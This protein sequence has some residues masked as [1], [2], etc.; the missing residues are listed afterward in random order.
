[1]MDLFFAFCCF[2]ICHHRMYF[3]F[4]HYQ[5]CKTNVLLLLLEVLFHFYMVYT[6]IFLLHSY[7]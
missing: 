5:A 3:V 6:L 2:V 4:I 7:M 1:M